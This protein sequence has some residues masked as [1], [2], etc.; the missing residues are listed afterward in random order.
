MGE[1]E[2]FSNALTWFL[3]YQGY[4]GILVDNLS[5]ARA[6]LVAVTGTTEST[7]PLL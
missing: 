5:C 1:E 7:S 3:T 6:Y 2:Q 4:H